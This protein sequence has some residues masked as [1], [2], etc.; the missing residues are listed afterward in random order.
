MKPSTQDAKGEVMTKYNIGDKVWW[1]RCE[2]VS[3]KEPCSVCFG[4]MQVILILGNGDEVVLPCDYCGKGWEIPRGY[5]RAQKYIA[6]PKQVII[7][8]RKSEATCSGEKHT[9]YI[10]PYTPL[11]DD[12]VFATLEE[13]TKKCAEILQQKTKDESTKAELIKYDTQKAFSWNAGYHMKI[14][15]QAKRDIEYHERMAQLCKERSREK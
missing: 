11:D 10:N 5:T 7:T 14:V 2:M 4:K 1:A 15:K 12:R 6:E 8:S 13:A 9:Y 3:V